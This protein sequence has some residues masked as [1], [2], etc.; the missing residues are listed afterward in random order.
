MVYLVFAE[1]SIKNTLAVKADS[2]SE[3]RAKAAA[4]LF[5]VLDNDP[6]FPE[7]VIVLDTE[8]ESVNVTDTDA[9]TGFSEEFFNDDDDDYDYEPPDYFSD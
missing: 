2:E 5:T 3:A 8:V 4:T 6:M 9:N 1:V 7:N